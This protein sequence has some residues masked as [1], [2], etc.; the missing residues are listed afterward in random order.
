MF[1]LVSICQPFLDKD[2]VFFVVYVLP[3]GVQNLVF[4]LASVFLVIAVLQAQA[5]PRVS[6]L[7]WGFRLRSYVVKAA[8]LFASES[9]ELLSA[10]LVC[11]WVYLWNHLILFWDKLVLVVQKFGFSKLTRC[12]CEKNGLSR[13]D[14]CYCIL[15]F[16]LT[17]KD[18]TNLGMN[19]N[20]F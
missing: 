12:C 14:L 9:Y 19:D 16:L 4:W 18:Y 6:Q 1:L 20:R 2:L 5:V 15:A 3:N 7:S 17:K 11:C 10:V 8:E 13:D